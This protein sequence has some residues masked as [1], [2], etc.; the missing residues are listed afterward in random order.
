MRRRRRDDAA[1]RCRQRDAGDV[2]CA[3]LLVGHAAHRCRRRRCR[4]IEAGDARRP[5]PSATAARAERRNIRV[6]RKRRLLRG[7]RGKRRLLLLLKRERRSGGDAKRRRRR[8][9]VHLLLLLLLLLLLEK[10]EKCGVLRLLR[11]G[12][13]GDER[14]HILRLLRSGS[15]GDGCG[16]L[17]LLLLLLLEKRELTSDHWRLNGL[18]IAEAAQCTKKV[19]N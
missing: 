1:A 9:G 12:G 17:R 3:L 14:R 4:L 18:E 15:G 7:K 19:K 8:V 6:C 16:R 10:L 2:R 11:G 5:L 13:C